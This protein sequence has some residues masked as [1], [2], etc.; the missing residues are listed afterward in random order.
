MEEAA[1]VAKAQQIGYVGQRYIPLTKVVLGQFATRI[2]Q[3]T[4]ERG[5]FCGQPPLQRA[6]AHAQYGGDFRAS[7]FAILQV[8]D[9]HG[10]GSMARLG[11]VQP[12][13][14][15][16]GDP[17]MHLSELRMGGRQWQGHVGAREQ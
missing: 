9:D 6:F 13:E 14:V 12:L 15:F 5:S 11:R 3:Q 16:A 7:R 2:V 4:L 1:L 10:T 8:P 17:L